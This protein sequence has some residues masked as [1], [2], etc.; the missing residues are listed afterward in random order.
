MGLSL[1]SIFP[2]D[3][4]LNVNT[5]WFSQFR[6][7]VLVPSAP[8]IVHIHPRLRHTS[9]TLISLIGRGLFMSMLEYKMTGS[10]LLFTPFSDETHKEDDLLCEDLFMKASSYF[11]VSSAFT[12]I[13]PAYIVLRTEMKVNTYRPHLGSRLGGGISFC[14]D[15]RFLHLYHVDTYPE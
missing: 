9:Y 12:C 5:A 7:H 2:W 8:V 11:L 6:L 10:C 13:T 15:R 1:K 3:G 4:H 14:L